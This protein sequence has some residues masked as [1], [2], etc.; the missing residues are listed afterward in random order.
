MESKLKDCLPSTGEPAAYPPQGAVCPSLCAPDRDKTCFACCPP[1]RPASYEHV[2][3]RAAVA[4]MLRENTLSFRR[5]GDGVSPIR[6][7][8]CWAL[9]FLD[10]GYHLVGCLLHPAQNRGLD[11]R[12]RVDFGEK[13]RRETCPEAKVFDGLTPD[14]KRCWL[15]LAKGLDAFTYSSRKHNPLFNMMGWGREVLEWVARNRQRF[16]RDDFFEV[17]PFFKTTLNPRGHAY[18]LS[19]ILLTSQGCGLTP[20]EYF[21]DRFERFSADL[22]HMLKEIPVCSS[23]TA[24]THLLPLDRAFLDFL[25]LSCGLKRVSLS[26]AVCMKAMVDREIE[27]FA[28][29]LLRRGMS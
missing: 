18:L 22:I 13:C 1:I 3:H 5:R 26:A 17:Y 24:Y 15:C 23:Q 27:G 29:V 7:F 9:G 8:S 20:S 28:Q 16:S 25:R 14:A 6:G 2:D 21:K 10:S 12:H 11:L 4:R 19:H